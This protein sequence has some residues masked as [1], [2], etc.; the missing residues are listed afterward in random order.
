M[1]LEF[2]FSNYRSFKNPACFSMVAAKL[3]SRNRAL[4]QSNTFTLGNSL[5]LL[6]S[7]AIYGANA[8]GKSNLIRAIAFVRQFVLQSSKES[9]ATEPIEVESFKLSTQTEHLPSEFEVIFFTAGQKYRYGFTVDTER[10]HKEWLYHTPVRREANLFTRDDNKFYV[11]GV[12]SEGKG[13]Q[14]KTRANALFLSVVAQFNGPISETILRWFQTLH[15]I[16]GL[17]D[18]GYRG[19]TIKQIESDISKKE[20]LEFIKHIDVGISDVQVRK[21]DIDKV[22]FPK[23]MPKALKDL[24]LQEAAPIT[25][26]FSLHNKYDSEGL[27][28]SH[29]QFDIENHESEGTKKALFLAGPLLDIINKSMILFIDE[30]DA[31]LHPLI[32][33]FIIGIF[34]SNITNPHNAQLVFATHDTNLLSK[35]CFR[36]D[37]I[38]FTEKD[39]YGSSNL[40]SL[41]EYKIRND[42]SFEKDYIAGKYGAIPFIGGL[43]RVLG[44]QNAPET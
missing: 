42:A 24:L 17:D 22:Q 29:E 40:Y 21:T 11:S 19:F 12:F 20:I 32:T 44:E 13:L 39:K 9:L 16:S 8:S 2:S 36:R 35:E 18:F 38:W 30:L 7:A 10:V 1:L 31:R 25:H 5:K 43:F 4:D 28:I 26:V 34:N 3:V 14:S 6:K 33:S 27:V 15:V 23:E 37:Q 41:A